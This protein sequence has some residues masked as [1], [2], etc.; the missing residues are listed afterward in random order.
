[1]EDVGSLI[2][3]LLIIYGFLTGFTL[4]LVSKLYSSYFVCGTKINEIVFSSDAWDRGSRVTS[5]FRFKTKD[6]KTKKLDTSL[7]P[8]TKIGKKRYFFYNEDRNKIVAQ[9]YTLLW[10]SSIFIVSLL[11]SLIVDVISFV[12]AIL[13]VIITVY[14]YIKHYKKVY[15]KGNKE[16]E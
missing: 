13:I 10:Q 1:M 8:M 15:M 11:F 6:G 16:N 4:L 3:V 5:Q 14:F 7:Y 2:L 9:I 12:I